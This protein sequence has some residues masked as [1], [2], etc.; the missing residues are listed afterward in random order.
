MLALG[1]ETN[2]GE[3]L[4]AQATRQ[5]ETLS[6]ATIRGEAIKV[7]ERAEEVQRR[8]D[9]DA[10]IDPNRNK[11]YGYAATARYVEGDD[12]YIVTFGPPKGGWGPYVVTQIQRT[13]KS[14]E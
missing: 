14:P 7:G 9:P 5:V 10:V 8:L 12:I 6:E 3:P 11:T 13:K 1:V 4:M 2:T